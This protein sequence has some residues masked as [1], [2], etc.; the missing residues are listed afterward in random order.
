MKKML[1]HKN[2]M[3]KMWNKGL[4]YCLIRLLKHDQKS[5]SSFL[6]KRKES[7]RKKLVWIVWSTVVHNEFADKHNVVEW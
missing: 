6:N 5:V 7:W 3:Y 1:L 4:Q 2:E